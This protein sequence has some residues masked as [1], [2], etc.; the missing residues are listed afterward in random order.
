MPT[1][2]D[3]TL[4]FEQIAQGFHIWTEFHYQDKPTTYDEDGKQIRPNLAVG[5]EH[6]KKCPCGRDARLKSHT[7]PKRRPKHVH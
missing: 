3:P 5:F 4:T 1:N 6:W 7:I 2:N